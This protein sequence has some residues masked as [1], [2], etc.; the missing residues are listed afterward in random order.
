[1]SNSIPSTPRRHSQPKTDPDTDTSSLVSSTS[2]SEQDS[3]SADDSVQPEDAPVMSTRQARDTDSRTSA[4]DDANQSATS[5]ATM[6]SSTPTVK[7]RQTGDEKRA[8]YGQAR[9]LT[10]YQRSAHVGQGYQFEK[11]ITADGKLTI[12]DSKKLKVGD[13]IAWLRTSPA[14]LREIVS[15][16]CRS[17][18]NWKR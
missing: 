6:T 15:F 12:R 7:K 17:I 14:S 5:Q 9:N 11:M 2:S 18:P 13:L 3:A 8:L 4:T 10:A 1:M 16:S